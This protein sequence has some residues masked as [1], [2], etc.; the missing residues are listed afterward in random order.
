MRT[1]NAA[2]RRLTMYF[3]T[4]AWVEFEDTFYS[5]E[6]LLRR[7]SDSKAEHSPNA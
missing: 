5:T 3:D 7:I 6:E 1:M 2:G 4:R